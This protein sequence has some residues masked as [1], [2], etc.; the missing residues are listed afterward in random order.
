MKRLVL[1]MLFFLLPA[2]LPFE[3]RQIS[4][5]QTG[6]HAKTACEEILQLAADLRDMDDD[7]LEEVYRESSAAVEESDSDLDRLRLALIHL[8][9]ETKR[10]AP[11]KAT[12]LLQPF[13][14][15]PRQL[16]PQTTGMVLVLRDH[17]HAALRLEEQ[18]AAQKK[19]ASREQTALKEEL[20]K[21]RKKSNE[22]ARKLQELL[23][24]DQLLDERQNN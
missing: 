12:A 8:T 9:P 5:R 1:P 10:Y 17:A 3:I 24:I 2:C 13:G 18:L 15:P 4:P 22:M 6:I 11:D 21:A 23:E 20:A 14:E 16:D 7:D 19:T